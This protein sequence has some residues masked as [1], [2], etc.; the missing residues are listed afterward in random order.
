[1]H[2]LLSTSATR[3]RCAIQSLFWA[4]CSYL[5]AAVQIMGGC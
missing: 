2:C 5:R 3:P 4:G 1:M